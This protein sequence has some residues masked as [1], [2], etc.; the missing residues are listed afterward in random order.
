Y[1]LELRVR[2]ADGATVDANCNAYPTGPVR[3]FMVGEIVPVR[4]DPDD[5]SKVELD[6]D[7][8]K[9]DRDARREEA[10]RGLAELADRKLSGQPPPGG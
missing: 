4:Y 3:A 8:I 10:R 7:A 6:R 1:H 5:R 2:L 9:A